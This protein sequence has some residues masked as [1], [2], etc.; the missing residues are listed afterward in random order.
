[1]ANW[2]VYVDPVYNVIS[3]QKATVHACNSVPGTNI[4]NGVVTKL[5]EG[6]N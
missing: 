3:V 2:N 4:G 1:M 5:N 6:F